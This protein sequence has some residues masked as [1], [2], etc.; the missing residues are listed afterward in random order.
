[1][2]SREDWDRWYEQADPWRYAGSDQDRMRARA[3]LGRISRRHFE[4]AL[5]LGCGEGALT[6]ALSSVAGRM[7]GYD[8][9]D[10]ALMRARQ[11]YP[12]IEFRQGDIVDVVNRDEVTTA[13]FDLIVVTEV[14]YY[15]QSDRERRE[16]IA[17][18]ARLGTDSCLFHFSVMVTGSR[19]TG[20]YFTHDE[21]LRMLSTHFRVLEHFPLE[22]LPRGADR[23]ISAI[24][25]RSVRM[26]LRQRLVESSD[27][28]RWKHVGYLAEKL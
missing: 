2:R 26:P 16:V 9:S 5:D 15:L 19:P 14:L 10:N 1:M 7:V 17:C 25:F 21:F 8:I 11:R 13:P 23:I 27:P 18:L 4:L 22:T 28:S 3:I 20:R 6:H 12:E 24:P